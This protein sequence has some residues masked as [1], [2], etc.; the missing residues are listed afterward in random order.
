MPG[1]PQRRELSEVMWKSLNLVEEGTLD[2]KGICKEMDW[3]PKYFHA[4]RVGNVEFCGPIA[5]LYMTEFKKAEEKRD[6]DTQVMLKQNIK[7]AQTL[8]GVI[9]TDF[10][11]SK[12][13]LSREDKKLIGT[14]TNCL[15]NCTPSVTV[16]HTEFNYVQG[17]NPQDLISEF[18]RLTGVATQSFNRDPIPAA[19][20]GRARELLEAPEPG[21]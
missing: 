10:N 12:K 20:E 6:K 3:T 4:L 7:T 5:E 17:L 8:L 9:L 16:K 11:N 19:A 21:V 1:R 18:K 14:L 13:K 2:I 15:S